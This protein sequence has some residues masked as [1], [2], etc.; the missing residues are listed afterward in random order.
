MRFVFELSRI[1]DRIATDVTQKGALCSP[2]GT[3]SEFEGSRSRRASCR[4]LIFLCVH[5]DVSFAGTVVASM[6]Q[7]AFL[8]L[9][10]NSVM[11]TIAF[12]NARFLIRS[13]VG[14]RKLSSSSLDT[15]DSTALPRKI[16]VVGGGLAGL[17][18]AFHLLDKRKGLGVTVFD[19]AEVGTAGASSVAGGYVLLTRT[20]MIHSA[21]LGLFHIF[22]TP[23]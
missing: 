18:A 16:A 17:S 19:K 2:A 1:Q 12:Q 22:A 13:P 21:C 9:I 11:L 8:C 23:H 5:H 6:R 4:P 14:K 7:L 20:S 10:I 3:Y 15:S